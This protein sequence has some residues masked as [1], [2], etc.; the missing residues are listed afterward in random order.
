MMHKSNLTR[1]FA[2]SE[3]FSSTR[4][5]F[6]MLERNTTYF[7]LSLKSIIQRDSSWGLLRC[8]SSSWWWSTNWISQG[9]SLSLKFFLPQDST[10][11][12]WR[13]TRLIW[14]Y[15]SS[16]WWSTNWS[17]QSY[18]LGLK[19]ILPRSECTMLKR[20]QD[21]LCSMCKMWGKCGNGSGR[22]DTVVYSLQP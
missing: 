3:V 17:T 7:I 10:S 22:H 5:Y 11:Q 1:S 15:S 19:S 18:P 2:E 13:G 4:F 8:Y 20:T 21:Y 9:Y 14:C 6:T 12:C 16:W